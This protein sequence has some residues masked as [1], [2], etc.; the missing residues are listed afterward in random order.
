MHLN[1]AN[2][3]AEASSGSWARYL[4]DLLDDHD[5]HDSDAPDTN[6]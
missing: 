6:P 2:T 3:W 4:T 1:T 5:D